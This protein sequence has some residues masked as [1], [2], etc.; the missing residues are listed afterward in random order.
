MGPRLAHFKHIK[1]PPFPSSFRRP[2][3][4]HRPSHTSYTLSYTSKRPPRQPY[5]TTPIYALIGLCCSTFAYRHY[6]NS[7]L[8]HHQNPTHQR[9][10]DRNLIFSRENYNAGRWWTAATCTLMHSDLWHLAFN[11]FALGSFGPMAIASFGLR[12]T[13]ILWVGSSLVSSAAI[14]KGEDMKMKKGVTERSGRSY[15]GA[16]GSLFGIVT[17]IACTVPKHKIF[18]FPI[19]VPFP[20]GPAVSVIGAMSLVAY[21]QDWAPA[22]SHTGHLGGMAFGG[23]YYLLLL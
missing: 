16:S 14:L 17:A 10:I 1:P 18:V 2:Y 13:A 6:A 8:S 9:F 19:P 15:V 11:M 4:S 3:S 7:Q 23:L 22:L 21:V 5:T 20:M 12:P